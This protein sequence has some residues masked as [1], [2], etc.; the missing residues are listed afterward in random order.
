MSPKFCLED[1]LKLSLYKY[2]DEVSEIVDGAAKESKIE[3]KVGVIARTWDDLKFTFIE[4]K[5]TWELGPL[6]LI[7]ESVET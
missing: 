1:L 2:A 6:D 3:S 4:Q 5:D 7:I